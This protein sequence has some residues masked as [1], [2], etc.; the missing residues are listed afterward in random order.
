[1]LS[2][3]LERQTKKDST[4]SSKPPS[5]TEKDESSI[6]HQGSNGKGKIENSCIAGNTRVNQTVTLAEVRLCDVCGEDFSE[7]PSV[8]HE[9]RTKIDIVFEKVVEHVDAE[10][11]QCPT[12]G[13]TIKG[14]FPAD[15]PGPLQ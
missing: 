9:R 11:K 14:R 15:M 10:I 1:M 6:A 8:H 12:C 3:F 5:Q 7:A 2:I 13:S 4:N